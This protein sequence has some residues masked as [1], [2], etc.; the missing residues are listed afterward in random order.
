MPKGK[1]ET[2]KINVLIMNLYTEMGGGE[3]AIY[4]LLKELNRDRFKPIMMF[5]KRGQFVE[6]VEALGIETVII[7]FPVV[8]LK[9]LVSP[10]VLY[11][12]MKA[13][14]QI[15]SYVKKNDIDII[16]CTDL[17]SLIFLFYPVI[18]FGIPV[19]YNIIFFYEWTRIVLFNLLAIT[20]VNKIITNSNAIRED[21]IKRTVYLANKTQVIYYGIDIT[22]FRPRRP[23]EANHFRNEM[24]V[25][26]GTVLIGMVARFD[27]WKGH[28][29][30]LTAAANILK[31]KNN[32]RF[33]VI[34]GL[35]NQAEV[36][37][38]QKYYDEVMNLRARLGIDKKLLFI[39]NRSDMPEVLRG[40]DILVCPSIREPIPLIVFE[41][42]ASGLPVI[43]ADSGGIPEQIENGKDGLL[44]RT[45]EA[46][47][48]ETAI[49]LAI[50]SPAQ[51]AKF[52]SAAREKM[53]EKFGLN[54]YVAT[55]EQQ[56]IDMMA[57]GA[58]KRP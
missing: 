36:P 35:F 52:A 58:M 23:E 16:H 33:V 55:M 56:Y 27:V 37:A 24:S 9:R 12:C 57:S 19:L 18:R 6:K 47:S 46:A 31:K 21:L 26:V 2:T 49:L 3:Y 30:Y 15:S 43:G 4:N 8:M 13:S 54:R 14:K 34:G 28:K 51:C 44:F 17:L 45:D 41:A 7:P 42:M 5:N 53:E 10:V 22:V 40:L 39:Q 38:I 32:V 25:P 29:T 11:N 1:N 50:D 48:L 20:I